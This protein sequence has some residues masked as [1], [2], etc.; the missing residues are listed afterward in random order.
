MNKTPI[1]SVD[2]RHGL[3]LF[4]TFYCLWHGI[5]IFPFYFVLSVS[6]EIKYSYS[7]AKI[8]FVRVFKNGC[9]I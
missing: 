3:T 2:I 9:A 7:V 6:S 1:N 4:F 5:A 8:L